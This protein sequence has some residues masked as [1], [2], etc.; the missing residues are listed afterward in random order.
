MAWFWIATTIPV[1]LLALGGL[2]GGL[3]AVAALIYMTSLI[4]VM[5]RLVQGAAVKTGEGGEFPSGMRLSLVLGLAHFPLMIVAVLALA[6]V[7]GI[8]LGAKVCCFIAFGLFFG[9]VSNANAHE[10]IHKAARFPRRLGMWVY[11][12][13]LF[14]HHT[15]AHPKVHHIW[16]ATE[17]DPNSPREGE[18]FYQFWP[19]AW[20]GSF[21]AGWQAENAMRARAGGRKSLLH[22]YVIYIGGAV[23]CLAV[24]VWLAGLG[25]VL[26]YVA[27]ASYGSMQLLLSDYVQHYGLHRLLRENGKPEPVGPEHSWNAPQ[28]F[29]SALMLNAPRHS[30]HHMAP[31][32]DYPALRLDPEVM[33][34]LP[35][36]L[37]LMAILALWPRLWR[38]VMD[39]RVAKLRAS[40]Q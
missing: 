38:Q 15:S 23:L 7:T 14:G 31:T 21:K 19:R 9:Q 35:Q 17:K 30:D 32:R 26:A 25:G 1:A 24:A 27:L 3:W 8:S 34:I 12:S 16:V 13:L 33:P 5:D 11:I 36:S 28:L 40:Q 6:G 4:H 37:P 20:V 29:T 22:P 2:L 10:L 18:N 39:P